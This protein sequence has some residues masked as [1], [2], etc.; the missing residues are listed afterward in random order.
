MHQCVT[1]IPCL[2]HFC[3]GCLA[4]W[5]QDKHSCPYCS[6]RIIKAKRNPLVDELLVE[7][8]MTHPQDERSEEDRT[9]LERRNCYDTEHRAQ[10][11]EPSLLLTPARPRVVERRPL[12]VDAKPMPLPVMMPEPRQSPFWQGPPRCVQCNKNVDG[13]RCLK[14]QEH[15]DCFLCKQAMP[16]RPNIPQ[17]CFICE[18]YFCN[19][20]FR[21]AKHCDLGIHTID[22]YVKMTFTQI[23]TDALCENP[24]EQTVLRDALRRNGMPIQ[25]LAMRV[26]DEM[27]TGGLAFTIEGKSNVKVKH[28]THL[29]GAC[30]NA[31]WKEVLMFQRVR[32]NESLPDN[33]RTRPRCRHGV[34]CRNQKTIYQHASKFNHI[35]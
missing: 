4:G 1:L 19:I 15:V 23:P 25:M 35:V 14:D 31:L 24:Y 10:R 29:C 6:E 18:L 21:R 12:F 22:W 3:G 17:Q 8:L 28:D 9:D 27:H 5:T 7:Y 20:Y 16:Y 13:Y 2:H 34:H 30:A 11:R 32:I 26:M 33:V